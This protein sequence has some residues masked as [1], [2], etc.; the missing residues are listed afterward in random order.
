MTKTIVEFDMPSGWD[1][2]YVIAHRKDSNGQII[3]INLKYKIIEPN[4]INTHIV[5]T[6]K[7]VKNDTWPFECNITNCCGVG[8]IT[9]E[10][11]CPECGK[12]IISDLFTG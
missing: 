8:P 10:K 11:Y 5:K 4:N 6:T 3:E 12:K 9:N 1:G 2:F 7:L